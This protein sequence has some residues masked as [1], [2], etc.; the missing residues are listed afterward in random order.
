MMNYFYNLTF[1]NPNITDDE[2][3]CANIGDSRCVLSMNDSAILLSTDH[4]THILGEK[5]RIE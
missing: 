4:K 3:Y 1:G 5:R 2:I